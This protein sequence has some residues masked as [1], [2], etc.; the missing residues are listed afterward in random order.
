MRQ[1]QTA[2]TADLFDMCQGIFTKKST[3][4]TVLQRH[5]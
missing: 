4:I 3:Q 5:L 1:R 2:D